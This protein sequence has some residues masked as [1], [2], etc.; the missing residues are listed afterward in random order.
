MVSFPTS[1]LKTASRRGG[2]RRPRVLKSAK[3]YCHIA[4]SNSDGSANAVK[5]PLCVQ[6]PFTQQLLLAA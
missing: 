5:I 4:N 1:M 6:L 3:N 2:S